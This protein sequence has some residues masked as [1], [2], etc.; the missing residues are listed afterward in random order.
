MGGSSNHTFQSSAYE[1][2]G[3]VLV[4]RGAFGALMLVYSLYLPKF[5][6][7]CR[8]PV[9]AIIPPFAF[10]RF[11]DVSFLFFLPL[12]IQRLFKL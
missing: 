8:R 6:E 12:L 1:F 3:A 2:L 7:N 11:R 4:A 5:A 9:Y 10:V